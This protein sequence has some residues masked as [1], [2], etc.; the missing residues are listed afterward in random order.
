MTPQLQKGKHTRSGIAMP[1]VFGIVVHWLGN[2]GQGPGGLIRYFDSIRD[3]GP[4]FASYHYVIDFD[5]NVVC[6]IPEDEVAWHAGPS[7][8]TNPVIR[9]V[10]PRLP[11]WCTVGVAICHKEWTGQPTAKTES[12]LVALCV[13]VCNRHHLTSNR[14][15]RHN[16]ITGKV[17]PRWYV[18]NPDR[19]LALRGEIAKHL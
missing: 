19:W 11:N 6:L 2:A 9:D 13:D 12:S 18:D 17:C 1:N 5:G 15:F 7:D 10:L 3:N 8:K 4:R 16:D 14:V